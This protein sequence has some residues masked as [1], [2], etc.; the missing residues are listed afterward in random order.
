[1]IS[2]QV[3]RSDLMGNSGVRQIGIQEVDIVSI[4]KSITKCAVLVRDPLDIRYELEKAVFLATSG[5]KRPF[6]VDIPL[7]IQAATIDDNLLRT[8]EPPPKL[9]GSKLGSDV[10]EII[11]LL[12]AAERPTVLAGHGVRIAGAVE[13]FRELYEALGIPVLTTW[14]AMD[15]IPAVHRLR[16]ESRVSWR[17]AHQILPCRIAT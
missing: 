8:F 13:E 7:D 3:K 16:W 9:I 4:V 14:N 5:R 10:N 12:N 2:G 15:L 17:C 6:W 11:D 1:M